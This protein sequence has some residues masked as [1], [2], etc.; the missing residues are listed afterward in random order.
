[1][2]AC[3]HA[4]NQARQRAC[5]H[6]KGSAAIASLLLAAFDLDEGAGPFLE[7]SGELGEIQRWVWMRHACWHRRRGQ[8]QAG[9]VVEPLQDQALT[10]NLIALTV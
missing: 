4:R 5:R 8:G 7:L 10:Q 6:A 2:T 3:M 9:R 1:M